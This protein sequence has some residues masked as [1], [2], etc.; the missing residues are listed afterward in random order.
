VN[1]YLAIGVVVLAV[2]YTGYAVFYAATTPPQSGTVR[3]EQGRSSLELAPLVRGLSQGGEVLFIHTE[4]SD[5]D[6]ARML[7][8]MMGPKVIV[9]PSLAKVPRDLLAEVYV[10]TNGV[11]GDGPFGYQVDVFDAVPGEA[12]YTPLRRVVLVTWR[13]GVKPRILSSVQEIQEA[14]RKGEVVVNRTETV[15]NMPILAWPG[16]QR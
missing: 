1:R 6:I 14:L 15:V 10:F 4:A 5:R 8:R 7:T 12:R 3:M 9:V 16:G 2:L 13:E 11:R